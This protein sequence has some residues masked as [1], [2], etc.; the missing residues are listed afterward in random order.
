MAPSDQLTSSA[1]DA[2]LREGTLAG[3]WTLDPARSQVLLT[4]RH[5]WGLRPL[6]GVFHEVAGTGTVTPGGDATGVITVAAGSIDTK[7]SMRD[8]HLRSADFFDAATHP[9]VT[10]SVDGVSPAG[11]GVRITGRLAIRDVTRPVTLD[12]TVSAG[13]DEVRLD[14]GIQ[15]DRR[16]FG[17]TW[18]WLGIASVH[19]TISVHAVFTRR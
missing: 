6:H 3:T 7:N 4:T 9:D 8:K 1:L 2:L 14:G 17:M 16:D 13:E 5:T 11:D 10:V 18:N 12:A 15:V 19:N